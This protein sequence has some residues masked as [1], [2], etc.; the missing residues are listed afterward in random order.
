MITN[1]NLCFLKAQ[2]YR[3]KNDEPNIW[4]I[5]N[6]QTPPDNGLAGIENVCKFS[7]AISQK[8]RKIPIINV[9]S[10]FSLN[11]PVPRPTV[12][13]SANKNKYQVEWYRGC[14][15]HAVMSVF[16]SVIANR[17]QPNLYMYN[18]HGGRGGGCRRLPHTYESAVSRM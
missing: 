9:F 4:R 12:V 8:Q 3:N 7:G 18:A 6:T 10:G 1:R 13:V 15:A 2:K 5:P 17:H 11:Q 14:L 16:N